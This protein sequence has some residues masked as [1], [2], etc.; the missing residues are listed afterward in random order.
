[1]K[2][3]V[4][5]LYALVCAMGVLTACGDDNKITPEPPTPPTPDPS[6]VIPVDQLVG[7]FK[8]N[9]GVTLFDNTT[10]MPQNVQALKATDDAIKL[11]LKDFT[12]LT[13]NV[14]DIVLAHCTLTA[15]GTT[16]KFSGKETLKLNIVG[17]CPTTYSGTIDK[18]G[19]LALDIDVETSV[20]SPMTVKVK[21]TGKKLAGNESS[22]A[23]IAKF[24]FANADGIVTG[25]ASI[26]AETGAITFNV[27]PMATEEQLSALTPTIT[28]TSDKAQVTPASGVAQDF[29]NNKS[30]TYTVVAEDGT[31]KSYEAKAIKPETGTKTYD[32][33]SWTEVANPTNED[34]PFY[35]P[36]GWCSSNTGVAFIE[37]M[38]L[39]N[40][41]SNVTQETTAPH[42][43]TTAVKIETLDTQGADVF[44]AKIPKVTSG[45]L[46]LGT[47][48]TNVS[49]TLKS[50]Q[51][52]I[53][54][55]QKPLAV[56]GYYKYAPGSTYYLSSVEKA[57]EAT[58]DAT[59]TDKYMIAAVLYTT[60]EYKTDN[61]DCL[62]GV[63]IYTSDRIVAIGQLTGGSQ[64]KWKEFNIALNYKQEYDPSKLYRFAIICSSSADGATFSGAPGSVLMID[65]ITIMNEKADS[66]N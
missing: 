1:M 19:N 10:E 17:E 46:F 58:V 3:K 35:E 65:D 29:S 64:S 4:F 59:K 12:F 16:Y 48:M 38:S 53:Q 62:T 41:I 34:K 43:G 13:M 56:S 14:G 28:L 39:T 31:V 20:P 32:F 9:L 18:G 6:V 36:T 51:M 42:S 50:T 7:T 54:Y 21:Y 37:A 26:N 52:G 23:T 55:K 22:D 33:E 45:S 30:V 27:S 49:N 15:D 61:S 24:E 8:G 57:D 47:W 5:Y 66:S 63:D 11:E 44:I 60:T 25:P 40:R 2:K